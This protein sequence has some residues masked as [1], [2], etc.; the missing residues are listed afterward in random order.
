MATVD[1][2]NYALARAACPRIVSLAESTEIAAFASATYLNI[3]K[4]VMKKGPWSSLV[5][6]AAALTATTTPVFEYSY[7]YT[8][9]TDFIRLL[10]VNEGDPLRYDYKI[11]GLSGTQV[12]LIQESVVNIVY[13]ANLTDTTKWDSDLTEAVVTRL[14]AEFAANSGNL[15]LRQILMGEYRLAVME[16]LAANN[17]QSGGKQLYTQHMASIRESDQ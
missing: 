9:P 13:I 5:K 16:G 14:A 8:L 12:L 3:F 7:A 10:Q 4:E 6:R 2:V 17:A 1:I 15:Q 11:E